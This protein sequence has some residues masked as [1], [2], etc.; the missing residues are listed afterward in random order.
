MPT[1][2]FLPETSECQFQAIPWF[3]S[4]CLL[5]AELSAELGWGWGGDDS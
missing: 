3:H 2:D 1:A 5:R 4:G